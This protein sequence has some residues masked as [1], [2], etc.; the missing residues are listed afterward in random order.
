MP[1][2]TVQSNRRLVMFVVAWLIAVYVYEVV[3]A[4]SNFGLAILAAAV[5]IAVN[6]YARKKAS[7][8]IEPNRAFNFWLYVPAVLFL[9]VPVVV[10]LV[11]FVVAQNERTLSDDLVALLPFILKLGLPVGLLLWVYFRLGSAESA[12]R[13]SA[14]ESM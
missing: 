14:S 7:E 5:M 12:L 9:V 2:Q 13:K 10:Q 3:L 8:Q 6:L 4:A 1:L 11:R